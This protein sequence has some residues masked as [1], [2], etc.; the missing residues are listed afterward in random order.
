MNIKA[1]MI[2]YP[3]KER[4]RVRQET[5]SSKRIRTIFTIIFNLSNIFENH[6]MHPQVFVYTI[7]KKIAIHMKTISIKQ[8][9]EELYAWADN[10]INPDI[11]FN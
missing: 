9:F 2:G 7:N 6:M 10:H 4:K 1:T 5:N 3:S 11:H 8:E